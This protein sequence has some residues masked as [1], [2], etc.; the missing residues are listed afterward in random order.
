MRNAVVTVFGGTGFIGRQLVERLA[1][2]G[3]AVR[4]VT[5][6]PDRAGFLR[7]MGDVGQIAILPYAEDAAGLDRLVGGS[8]AVVNLLGILFERRAGDFMHVHRDLAERIAT[9]AAKAGVRRLVQVSAIGA[10]PDGAALY[11]RSKGEGEGRVRA[12]FPAA[13]I[14]RP[15]IVFGPND[16]F[17]TR[18]ARL[19]VIAP[20]LPLIKG[21]RTRFQPVYV[22]DVA[23]AIL[24]CLE[25]DAHQGKTFE[26]GGPRIATFAELLR[27]I[28]ETIR[29]RRPLV[30]LPDGIAS[31]K[32]RLAE[33]L[34]SPPLTRDQ[35]KLLE[36]DN[37]VSE[38]ALTFADL[39]ISPTPFEVVV[40]DYLR[41]FARPR[42]PQ[43]AA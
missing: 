1:Q 30:P 24:R 32:A 34:P 16:G 7:P 20:A 26:L 11:A 39:G 8:T 43:A 37:V 13:T 41:P 19:S 2:A 28:L 35:L 5:R 12:A 22:R 18:F 3:A 42:R 17:F 9:A 40:P 27:F 29:R 33:F 14:I 4:V 31:F 23:Q 25:T 10:D 38:G 6:D 15:S 36:T 21:G